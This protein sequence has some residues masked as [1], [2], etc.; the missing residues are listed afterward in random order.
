MTDPTLCPQG[1]YCPGGTS[2]PEPCPIGSY[3][4]SEGLQEARQCSSCDPGKYCFTNGIA[5]I[6]AQPDCDAGFLCI[7]G[8][9]RPEPTDGITGS[10]C[11]KGGSCIEGSI[12]PELCPA[13]T[14]N[15]NVGGVDLVKDC[16]TCYPGYYC[17]GEGNPAPDGPCPAGFYCLQGTE[18]PTL[19][20]P[21]GQYSPPGFMLAF[22]CA[23]GFYTDSVGSSV[24][25]P[26]AST[27][28]C[29]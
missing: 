17:E 23:P 14:F 12:T 16:S 29:D 28:Q 20:A 24:C 3:G 25:L 18:T 2:I 21:A 13:G 5:D 22:D 27:Q 11:P 1:F 19:Q 6:A 15:P 7:E 26:C 4:A 9:L 8:S 10:R